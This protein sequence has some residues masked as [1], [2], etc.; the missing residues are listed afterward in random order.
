MITNIDDHSAKK[1]RIDVSVPR[2]LSASRTSKEDENIFPAAS[3]DRNRIEIDV[4]NTRFSTART[5]LISGSAY[6]QSLLSERWNA[7]ENN[8]PLFLDQEPAPFAILLTYMRTG[9]IQLPQSD[10]R[11]C[12]LTFTLAEFLGMTSFLVEVKSTAKK[13]ISHE[14]DFERNQE[15]DAT[16]F[17]ELHGSLKASITKGILPRCYFAPCEILNICVHERVIKAPKRLLVKNSIYFREL[18]GPANPVNYWRESHTMIENSEVLE[19]TLQF[20]CHQTFNSV[21]YSDLVRKFAD[22]KGTTPKALIGHIRTCTTYL[23]ISEDA[24]ESVLRR[25]HEADD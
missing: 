12:E 4:G 8:E 11:L 18:L 7:E 19:L 3:H 23:G 1:P 16:K 25:M 6:F 17:D 15:S 24:C 21:L 9:L 2:N 20:I 5:T 14:T 22:G 10:F 13:R